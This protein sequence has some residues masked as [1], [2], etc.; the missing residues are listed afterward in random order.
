MGS[1]PKHQQWRLVARRPG[2][3]KQLPALTR[4]AAGVNFP[5]QDEKEDLVLGDSC[6][7]APGK[8]AL[9]STSPHCPHFFCTPHT[10]VSRHLSFLQ[11]HY[12][13]LAPLGSRL[14]GA[15]TAVHSAALR[16]RQ[17]GL[18][19]CLRFCYALATRD[20]RGWSSRQ[21]WT[22]AAAAAALAAGAGGAGAGRESGSRGALQAGMH[23]GQRAERRRPR[24]AEE[25]VQRF[26]W[27]QDAGG[28]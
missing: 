5:A 1:L 9:S 15:G 4:S 16:S 17:C 28:D 7:P 23:P 26:P 14:T 20:P 3:C 19:L 21:C 10:Q 22:E 8:R 2:G 18:H 13:P 11:G 12:S 25:G 6:A 27:E 24:A